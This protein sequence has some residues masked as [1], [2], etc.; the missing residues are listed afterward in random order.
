MPCEME[1]ALQQRIKGSLG[2]HRVERTH[3]MRW[4]MVMLAPAAAGSLGHT[5]MT[6]CATSQERQQGTMCGSGGGTGETTPHPE[7]WCKPS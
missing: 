2:L 4:R 7:N 6:P 5:K 1:A 3:H